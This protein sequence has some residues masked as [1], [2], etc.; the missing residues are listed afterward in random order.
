MYY[1]LL[2]PLEVRDGSRVVT[3]PP[4][5]QRALL[6]VLLVHANQ[7]L[8]RDRLIDALWGETPPRTATASL[9]NVV[10]RLRRTLGAGLLVTSSFGYTLRVGDG[11]LDVQHFD[12]LVRDGRAALAEGDPERAA[13]MLG[14]AL[15]LWRGAALAD[16]QDAPPL[17]EHAQRLEERRLAAL[18]D[19]IEA[20]L[21]RGRHAEVLPE[22]DALVAQHRLRERLR[23]QQMI[24]LYRSGRQADALA[25]YRDARR[26]LVAELGIEP[27]PALRGLERAV[28]DQDPVLGGAQ[29]LPRARSALGRGPGR[30]GPLVAAGALLVAGIAVAVALALRPAPG[31]TGAAVLPGDLV[32]AIDPVSNQIV[33]RATV[34]RTPTSVTTGGGAVWTLNASDR[35]ISRVDLKTAATRTFTSDAPPV[36][37]AAD[38]DG[39]WVAQAAPAATTV[40]AAD[41]Y[42]TPGT[43]SRLDPATGVARATTALPQPTM[44]GT[45]VPPGQLIAVGSAAAW[46]IT[47][48]G[49]LHRIDPRSGRVRTRRSLQASLIATGDGQVWAFGRAGGKGGALIRLDPRTGRPQSRIPVPA[50]WLT[51]L[52]VGEGAVWAVDRS[53]GVVWRV[54]PDGVARTIDVGRGA[55]GLAVGAG[56]VWVTNSVRGRVLRIDPTSNRVVKTIEVPGTPRG[57]AIGGGRVWVSLAGAGRAAPATG[58]LRPNARVSALPA[59]PCGGVLTDGGGDPDVLIASELPLGQNNATV[60]MS[61][62]IAF[63][64]RELRFRAGRFTV[65]LQSCNDATAQTG[66]VDNLVCRQ[67]ARLYAHNPH[68]V[69][70]VGPWNSGCASEMLPVLNT[71]PGGPLPLVSPTNSLPALVRRDPA[72]PAGED[73]LAELYPNGQRGYAR[74]Y[75]SDD[76]ELAAGAILAHRLGGRVFFLEDREF[77]ATLGNWLWFRRA[78]GRLGLRITGHARWDPHARDY[79]R[80]AERVRAS[81]ARSVY[82]NSEVAFNAGQMIRDLRA[83]LGPDVPIIGHYR[84]LPISVLYANTGPAARGVLI[85]SPGLTTA[86]LGPSG[87]RF[88][89]AF[90]ATQPDNH[91]N[92]LA[93]YAAAATEVLLDAI[94][95]SDGTRASVTRALA[96]TRLADSTLGPLTLDRHGEPTT[97]PITVVRVE[98][99]GGSSEETFGL[100]GAKAE[101][102]ITPPAKLVGGPASQ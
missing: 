94:A 40:A 38:D 12:A 73:R 3:L 96:T 30:L 21:A 95:R 78:A 10:S 52:A 24:A 82:L 85:T 36:D 13:A 76:Y 86:A 57:A 33:E 26:A 18:E 97:H 75:P 90:G 7:T 60:P 29:P 25:A 61:D 88:V 56:A 4:G 58:G 15:G 68:V 72:E 64:V 83:A 81:G 43:V 48:S 66:E 74:V 54:D 5:R 98:R 49:W 87:R 42:I 100:D 37:V 20:E 55:S 35:T 99:G 41:T 34:G 46:A 17:R 22:L 6:A 63:V 9:H 102:V 93:I 8:S 69:G 32:V 45:R 14:D 2:G 23:G 62:A 101:E 89:R 11:E 84:L 91:V 44:A 71:A 59:P 67:N 16:L 28:L 1:G 70:V 80:I 27:G 53:L 19:R 31:A 92:A 77:S 51:G 79:R 47:R 39:L 50:G 65:G